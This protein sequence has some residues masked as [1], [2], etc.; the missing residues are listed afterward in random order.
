MTH[1]EVFPEKRERP[2]RVLRVG[3]DLDDTFFDIAKPSLAIINQRYGKNFTRDQIEKFWYVQ[4]FLEQLGAVEEEIEF[5]RD[6]I[7]RSLDD[8]YRVYRDSPAIAGAVG[9]LKRL[10]RSGHQI[11]ALTSRPPGLEIIAEEQF[12]AVGIDWISVER[13]NILIRDKDYWEGMEDKEFKLRAI[14]GNFDK[15][16]YHGFPGLDLHLDDMGALIHHKSAV[17]IEDKIFILARKYNKDVPKTNLVNNWWVFY[18]VIRCLERGEDLD[19]LMSHN[20][21][22]ELVEV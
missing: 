17:G 19:W 1:P 11:F 2:F 16:K 7:Y 18:K 9:V 4:A 10:Y 8:K 22:T 6:E 20:V 3:F 21:D 13:G 12:R 14:A 5:F 15:G